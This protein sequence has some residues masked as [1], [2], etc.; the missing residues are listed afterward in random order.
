[1]DKFGFQRT[2][3]KAGKKFFGFS[4]GDIVRALVTSGKK[5]GTYTGKVAVRATGSFDNS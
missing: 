3:P 2:K 4:T 1:M 5:L